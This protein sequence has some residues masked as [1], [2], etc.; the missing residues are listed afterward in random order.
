MRRLAFKI[1]IGFAGAGYLVAMGMYF[2]P[3]TWHFSTKFVVAAC[4]AF[5][6]TT[7]SMADP[8]LAAIVIVIA[9]LMRS[10]TEL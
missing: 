5:L 7:L 2:A 8:S 9:R 3:V 6:V 10:C 4:P 1:V